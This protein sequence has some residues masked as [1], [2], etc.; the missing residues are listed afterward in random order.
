MI[1]KG[2]FNT[3]I[4]VIYININNT[5]GKKINNEISSKNKWIK[6]DCK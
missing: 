6:K 4:I 3:I 1:S 5:K 2:V